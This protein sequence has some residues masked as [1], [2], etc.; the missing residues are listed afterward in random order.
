M[1]ASNINVT[2]LVDLTGNQILL[3]GVSNNGVGIYAGAGAPTFAAPKGSLY[4][5]TDGSSSSTRA[6][7]CSVATGTWVAVTTAS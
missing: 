5:A 6:Y 3:G 2:N 1:T 4:L 7:I